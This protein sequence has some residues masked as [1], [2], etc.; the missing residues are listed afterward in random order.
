MRKIIFGM[1]L[2]IV[3]FALAMVTP[4]KAQTLTTEVER[5]IVSSGKVEEEG[6][7]VD[8]LSQI[9]KVFVKKDGVWIGTHWLKI[10]AQWR[11]VDGVGWQARIAFANRG[12]YDFTQEYNWILKQKNTYWPTVFKIWSYDRYSRGI[13]NHLDSGT[14]YL[15]EID[16]QVD[17]LN[18]MQI[19]CQVYWDPVN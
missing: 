6:T 14:D 11:F 13:W 18:W 4:V 12:F 1:L 16:C 2:T 3:G 10:T 17:S 15:S 5:E 19:P 8:Q 7:L 9:Y